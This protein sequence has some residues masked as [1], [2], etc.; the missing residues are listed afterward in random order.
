M[1]S[2]QLATRL[3]SRVSEIKTVKWREKNTWS[4]VSVKTLRVSDN[5]HRELTRLLGEMT[6]QIEKNNENN[7]DFLSVDYNRK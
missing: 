3:W 6:A 5:V 2:F 4:G 7:L 1:I